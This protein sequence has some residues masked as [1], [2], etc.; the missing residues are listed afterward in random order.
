MDKDFHSWERIDDLVRN[1]LIPQIEREEYD[2]ILSITRG[3]MI[4]GCLVSELLDIRYVLTAAVMFYTNVEETLTEPVFLQFPSDPLLVG[5]RVLI[6]DDVW[7][8]GKTAHSVRER[9][10]RAGGHPRVAVIHYKP[11][12]SNFPGDGPDFY[13][14]ETSSWIVYP[15]DPDR[16]RLLME[17]GLLEGE[18]R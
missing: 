7:D 4:P 13:A 6:V 16:E 15:W 14:A 17:E 3:G 8:S 5:K 2:A 12:K 9:V 11:S 1:R 10:R 18:S